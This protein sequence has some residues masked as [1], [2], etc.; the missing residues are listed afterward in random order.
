MRI[1]NVMGVA[2]AFPYVGEHG[3][4]LKAGETSPKL[5]LAVSFHKLF[6]ADV[7]GGKIKVILDDADTAHLQWLAKAGSAEVPVKPRVE[8]KSPAEIARLKKVQAL[9]KERARLASLGLL[10]PGG[11]TGQ[12]SFGARPSAPKTDAELR[13]SSAI[14]VVEPGQ[15]VSLDQLKAHNAALYPSK[16]KEARV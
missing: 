2:R 9:N 1:Q 4:T 15:A 12:P 3:R 10:N 8:P 14:P 16:V 13:K 11:G 7:D 6:R 5:P